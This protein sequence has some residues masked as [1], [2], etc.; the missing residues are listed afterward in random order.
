MGAEMQ[1]TT[2]DLG[3]DALWGPC[4]N[5]VQQN[6]ESRLSKGWHPRTRE[7]APLHHLAVICIAD[8]LRCLL[9]SSRIALPE[10]E[11]R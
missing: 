9:S 5:P 7:W 2:L 3:V 4:R 6:R 11:L 10:S 8:G 1:F